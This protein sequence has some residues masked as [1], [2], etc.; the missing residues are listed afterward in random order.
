MTNQFLDKKGRSSLV[1]PGKIKDR[2]SMCVCIQSLS[3]VRLSV[4]PW[5]VACQASLSF[6]IF[7]SLLKF[8]SIESVRLSNHLIH[9][10]QQWYLLWYLLKRNENLC[11]NIIVFTNVHSSI[12]HNSQKVKTTQ[13]SIGEWINKMR[14][15][16]ATENY[17]YMK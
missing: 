9:M 16:Y 15:H 2:I 14:Y 1:I 10:I 5:T 6:P 8:M 12:T 11:I 17:S 7:W 3:H 4:I 13:S